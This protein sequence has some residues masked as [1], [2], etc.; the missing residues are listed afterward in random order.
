MTA[1]QRFSCHVGAVLV[2]IGGVV[3]L[4]G[5]QNPRRSVPCEGCAG[6]ALVGAAEDVGQSREPVP[7][8]A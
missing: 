6:G 3:S 8:A 4:V 2:L 5:I 1:K 7:A